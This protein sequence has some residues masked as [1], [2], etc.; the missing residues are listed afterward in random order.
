MLP[1]QL[2]T[3]QFK[4]YPP[5]ARQ[6]ANGVLDLLRQLPLAFLPL[7]LRELIAYDWKF[8][9][10]QNELDRQIRYLSGLSSQQR[11][12]V[13]AGF[14][15][16]RLSSEL[17]EMPWAELPAKF[18]EKLSAELWATHQI[19]GF[20]KS[21][22]QYI[23]AFNVAIPEPVLSVPRL[24]I[25]LFGA[26]ADQSSSPLFRKLRPH[27]TYFTNVKTGVSYGALMSALAERARRHPQAYGHWQIDGNALPGVAH[28]EFT[29]VSYEGLTSLRAALLNKMRRLAESDAGPEAIHSALAATVPTEVGSDVAGRDPVLSRF[30]IS[31]FTE[32]SGTQIFSTTFVQWAAREALRRARPVTLLVRFSARQSEESADAALGGLRREPTYDSEGSLVDADMGAYYTWLNMQRLS[33]AEGS[34]FLAWFEGHSAA[35]A[36]GPSFVPATQSA[37]VVDLLTL[38]RRMDGAL[39]WSAPVRC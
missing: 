30:S 26:W 29:R 28:S 2:T 6:I 23:Q 39:S 20:H 18:S 19:D 24:G 37:E 21:A 33:G 34:S 35:V 14:A 32:G 25:V 11:S 7:L 8:P 3:D 12:L 1:N 9:A 10:E 38:F 5:R 27:G 15:R 13:M 4:T 31:L 36:I 22:E 17:D 16:L